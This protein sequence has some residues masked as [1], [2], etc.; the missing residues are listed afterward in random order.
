M[1]TTTGNRAKMEFQTSLFGRQCANIL[2]SPPD[3]PS[4]C[5]CPPSGEIGWKNIRL[6]SQHVLPLPPIY[7]YHR[8]GMSTRQSNDEKATGP[9]LQERPSHDRWTPPHST[10]LYQ[11]VT[12]EDPKS[13]TLD[14]MDS[15][16]PS[17]DMRTNYLR[18]DNPPKQRPMRAFSTVSQS[19]PQLVLTEAEHQ[20][21]GDELF[22]GSEEE[23][24]VS[25]ETEPVKSSAER[26]AEKR[27][28][29]RFR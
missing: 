13:T 28:M 27:K 7:T 12:V 23:E 16:L 21:D 17:P 5:A 26:L 19:A 22:T 20:S 9:Q 3:S 15:E 18:E 25:V 4:V 11:M 6:A 10:S 24:D 8:L 2:P 1:Q 14:L 29:K